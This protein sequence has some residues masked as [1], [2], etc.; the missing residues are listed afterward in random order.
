MRLVV[1]PLAEQDLEEIVVDPN[2][3]TNLGRARTAITL[4]SSNQQTTSSPSFAFCMVHETF[5]LYLIRP[6]RCA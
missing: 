3:Q 4:F 6:K 2:C 5:L 1:T